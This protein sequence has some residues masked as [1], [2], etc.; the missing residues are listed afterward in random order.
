MSYVGIDLAERTSTICRLDG[1]AS[2]VDRVECPTAA[3]DQRL[4]DY[5]FSRVIIESTPLAE[6]AASVAEAAGHEAVIIDARAAR[7][8][9]R[10]K[11]KTDAR[12]AYTLARLG[13]SGWYVEVHRKS[14]SARAMRSQIQ[15]RQGLI[16]TQRAMAAQIR[17]LLK[18]HGVCVG[19]VSEGEFAER[20]RELAAR[21]APLLAESL[22]A[23]L[24]LWARAGEQAKT[25]KRSMQRQRVEPEHQAVVEQLQS[26]PGVG[27]L[28]SRAYVATV[29][30]PQRFPRA[31][32]VADYL[33]LSPSVHQ[34]GATEY[35][36][37]ITK[38][39]DELLRWH[40]VEAANALLNR[41]PDC[42]LKRWAE[43]L[44]QRKGSAKAK[45]ALARKLAVLL[46]RLWR[47][48]ER[49]DA[50]RGQAQAA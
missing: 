18:A 30:D 26:V 35:R 45:V 49:F 17:G 32:A 10:S 37:R 6:W 36:G 7:H 34:S 38:E 5:P 25:L 24:E 50:Q 11:K 22:E 19:R 42:A 3:L 29:D 2:V 39:G 47:S 41:G 15:A 16:R 8:L 48:G 13:H 20:V 31:E 9:V 21:H 43:R 14:G 12:D 27:P 33:G 40:L 44:R 28:V 46:W 4:E 1:Q 23:L